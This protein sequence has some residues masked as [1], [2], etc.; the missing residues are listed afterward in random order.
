MYTKIEE[1]LKTQLYLK[2][3]K[4]LLIGDSLRSKRGDIGVV[5]NPAIT[6]MLP[7]ECEILAPP[8]PDVDMQQIPY[9]DSTFEY[10][11]ADQVLEHVRNP[12]TAV[13]EARRVLKRGGMV[14]LT[15]C[16]LHPIHGIPHDYW[17][18]TPAG[19]KVLC[20]NFD[21]IYQCEGIGNLEMAIDC[22][23]GKRG[24]QVVPGQ[25]MEKQSLMNDNKNLLHVWI[26][27]GTCVK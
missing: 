15:S 24:K 9:E 20:E 14:I 12:W 25:P 6:N 4:C 18:F 10:V 26:I 23:K 8:Y 2:I 22:F 13:E 5:N 19:L 1:F 21:I 27:A 16:L 3:G 17:R 11:I 7:K